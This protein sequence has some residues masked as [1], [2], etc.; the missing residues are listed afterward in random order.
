MHPTALV[1]V[2]VSCFLH[3]GWN[4]Q[5]KRWGASPAFF[6]VATVLVTLA[7]TPVFWWVVADG[8][9]LGNAPRVLWICLLITGACQAAYYYCLARA[10]RHGDVSLVYPLARTTPLFVVPLAGLIQGR[11][12]TLVALAGILLVVIG[13]FVLP[14][15]SLDL[16]AE[17][18]AWRT[19]AGPGSL[20][21]VAT[22]LASS[23]YT[24]ADAIGMA[25]LRGLL[26]GGRGAFAYGYLEGISTALWMA[27]PVLVLEG[28][29][30]MTRAY[31]RPER[32]RALLLGGQIFFTY[33]L[34]LAAY[35]LADKV[36][37]VAG[38]RQLSVVLG[39]LGGIHL[40]NEPGGGG[41]VLGSGIIV[42]GLA[43]I[44][45]AR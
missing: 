38:L 14:R 9:G 2:L 19:Y 22:A 20:W 18:I 34:V 36:A 23:G 4:L 26:P 40:L 12:P 37:Y 45:L 41:R 29:A 11:W 24:V 16:R 17:R 7:T 13:C 21:A 6:L 30:G 43:L 5:A 32:G 39:V 42:C 25:S 10:Y 33:L 35:G 1:L 44:A 28:K 27:L 31:S 3:A 8:G 15:R